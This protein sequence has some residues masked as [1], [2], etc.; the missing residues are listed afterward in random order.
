MFT[1]KWDIRVTI[2][3]Y[4]VKSIPFIGLAARLPSA[5]ILSYV[6][7]RHQVI[8]ILQR[9]SHQT[10]AYIYNAN[11]LPGF[12]QEFDIMQILKRAQSLGLLKEITKWQHINLEDLQTQ[13][14]ESNYLIDQVKILK[15]QYPCLYIYILDRYSG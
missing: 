7:Y 13:M 14:I 2:D 12:L 11:G 8:H 5:I 3:S 9:V 10:R 1:E 6:S 15:R 4:Y